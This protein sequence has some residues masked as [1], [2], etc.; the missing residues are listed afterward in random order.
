MD[1]VVMTKAVKGLWPKGP[2][3]KGQQR[4]GG[5]GPKP[6]H[7]PC[8]WTEGWS[9][10]PQLPLP[11]LPS[12]GVELRRSAAGLAEAGARG[13]RARVEDFACAAAARA[14]PGCSPPPLCPLQSLPP[15]SPRPGAV[16][17]PAHTTD[18][19]ATS[20]PSMAAAYPAAAAVAVAAA[21]WEAA[22]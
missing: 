15:C 3:H 11:S 14:R 16:Q 20:S 12:P 7:N 2:Q 10:L 1:T 9:P 19:D 21:L 8:R 18:D 13:A 6:G 17:A 4:L 5:Q 22:A